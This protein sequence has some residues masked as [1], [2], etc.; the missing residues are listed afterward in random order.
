MR[1]KLKDLYLLMRR[2]QLKPASL[3]FPKREHP[4]KVQKILLIR[5][6]RLGD[7]VLSIP[8][9][10]DIRAAYPAAEICLLCRPAVWPVIKPSRLIDRCIAYTSDMA[11]LLARLRTEKFDLAVDLHYD[12]DLLTAFICRMSGA[13]YCVGFELAQRD[14]FFDSSVRLKEKMHFI[15]ELEELARH[16]GIPAGTHQ[17]ELRLGAESLARARQKLAALNVRDDEKICMVHPGGFY[18][19]QR[20][21]AENFRELARYARDRHHCRILFAVGP[22][23]EY[24]LKEDNTFADMLLKNLS[25][26]MLCAFTGLSS[27][28][29]GNNSG[30]LHIACALGVPSLST[31]GPTDEARWRPVGANRAVLRAKD[32]GTDT[33]VNNIP[34]S[35]A[36]DRLDTLMPAAVSFGERKFFCERIAD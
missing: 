13:Q 15:A 24:L 19:K 25:A 35:A 1:K 10:A 26:D 17:P 27:I 4:A 31:L 28:F 11:A 16:L 23:E 9:F 29:A 33:N 2:L 34:V 30:P 21:A 18:P 3:L 36:K 5:A 32:F 14:V 22:S 20:W 8:F 6:D 12:T 7:A